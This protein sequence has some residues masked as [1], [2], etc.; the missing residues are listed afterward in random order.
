MQGRQDL[1]KEERLT[2]AG[3]KE[4]GR[5][6]VVELVARFEQNLDYYRSRDFD[7]LSTRSTFIDPLLEALGWDVKDDAGLG[8]AREVVLEHR[9]VTDPPLLVRMSGTAT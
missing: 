5:A 6:R 7:E 9:Q 8:P 3:S 4:D 2:P 1:P